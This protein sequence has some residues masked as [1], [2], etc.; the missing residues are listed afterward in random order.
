MAGS[1]GWRQGSADRGG[2]RAAGAGT[3]VVAA[4][5]IGVTVAGDQ[6]ELMVDAGEGQDPLDLAAGAHDIQGRARV[7]RPFT[8]GSQGPDSGAVDE[9]QPVQVDHEMVKARV[10]EL[11]KLVGDSPGAREVKLA[12]R[13]DVH[14]VAAG[15]DLH[16][17]RL[18]IK[19]EIMAFG[20]R[21][22]PSSVLGLWRADPTAPASYRALMFCL[23]TAS[24]TWL[25]T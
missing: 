19:P 3:P 11:V 9:R 7:T 4:A 21:R 8:R 18:G 17:K 1:G 20:R 24:K 23:H 6:P 22:R 13:R 12:D 16:P 2:G 5:R 14:P 25:Y 15:T 10:E